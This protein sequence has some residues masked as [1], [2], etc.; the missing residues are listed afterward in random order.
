MTT[1]SFNF[2][3]GAGWT[4][5]C[6]AVAVAVFD[7]VFMSLSPRAFFINPTTGVVHCKLTLMRA[8]NK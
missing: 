4:R 3:S 8:A 7:N 2:E 5:A 1:F 6:E